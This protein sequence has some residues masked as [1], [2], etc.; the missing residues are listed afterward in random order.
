VSGNTLRSVLSDEEAVEIASVIMKKLWKPV[1]DSNF[2]TIADWG[3]GFERM[4]KKYNGNGPIPKALFEK[5]EKQF[6]EL[7]SSMGEQVLLHGDLHHE[8]ILL[9]NRDNFLAI[10]PKGVIGEREYEVGCFLRNPYPDIIKNPNAVAITQRRLRQFADG[11]GFGIKRL[12]QWAFAQAV[13]SLIWVIEDREEYSDYY[14]SC[15][16][17][18]DAVAV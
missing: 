2:Q 10:D 12:Q 1:G 16:E 13:L 4:R 18:F 6:S 5:A 8:N 7:L 14:I 11:L 9:S 17:I 3:K 15:A